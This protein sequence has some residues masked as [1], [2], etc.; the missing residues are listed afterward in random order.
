[1]T[2]FSYEELLAELREEPPDPGP[3]YLSSREW[4]ELWGKSLP[5]SGALLREL[6]AKGLVQVAQRYIT[7]A[8][9][10]RRPIPVYRIVRQEA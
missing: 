7:D 9:G 8:A 10:T 2:D 3:E 1:M 6:R 5:R 4:A